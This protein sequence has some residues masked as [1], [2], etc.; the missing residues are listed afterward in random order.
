[1][2]LNMNISQ[3]N[4]FLL[5][6][7]PAEVFREYLKIKHIKFLVG[8]RPIFP[9]VLLIP[10]VLLTWTGAGRPGSA[11]RMKSFRFL[12]SSDFVWNF[13]LFPNLSQRLGSCNTR[14]FKSI[15]WSWNWKVVYREGNYGDYYQD[16]S[17][18]LKLHIG[19]K[20]GKYVILSPVC[21]GSYVP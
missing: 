21:G 18:I 3:V 9:I 17:I 15:L 14:I 7:L 10:I 20:V 2:F 5:Q 6:S 1:M 19:A 13:F 16:M 8:G 12:G 4:I 11:A